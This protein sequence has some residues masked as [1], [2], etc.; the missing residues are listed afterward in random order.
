MTNQN[1]AAPQSQSPQGAASGQQHRDILAKVNAHADR[2]IDRLLADIDEL[3]GDDLAN[4]THS[5]PAEHSAQRHHSTEQY[6][7]LQQSPV[8]PPQ[9]S[10]GAGEASPLAHPTQTATPK[11]N[12]TMPLWLKALLGISITSI[13]AGSLL[14]WL[15][16]ERKIVLPQTINTS[17]LPFQSQSQ[18]SPE[19]AKFADYMR[20]SMS[21][22]DAGT[23]TTL[24]T[25]LP[26]PTTSIVAP[27]P[28]SQAAPVATKPTGTIVTTTAPVAPT[29]VKA[30]ISLIKTLFQTGNRPSA[31]FEVDRQS[32][33]VNV[34][35]TIGTS[36]WS[37]LSVAKG[38]VTI[39]RKGGEIRSVNVGQKF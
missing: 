14:T 30:K 31:I 2:S 22:I 13:A 29:A 1:P 9:R 5:S 17:W 24:A 19:D 35:Q 32:K 26:N 7:H 4:D 28:T 36:N 3:L 38:E 15:V 34:G 37:L 18:V 27:T 20:K 11:P 25:N 21:K 16:N 33:I 39:K 10:I 8:Y 6:P 12:R 23:Q